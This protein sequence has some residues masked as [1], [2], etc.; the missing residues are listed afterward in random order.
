MVP[1]IPESSESPSRG[2]VLRSRAPLPH[3]CARTA[4]L[5]AQRSTRLNPRLQAFGRAAH[6]PA[7]RAGAR[8]PLRSAAP[9]L[10]PNGPVC[11]VQGARCEVRGSRCEVRGARCERCEVREVRN[12][13]EFDPPASESARPTLEFGSQSARPT[14]EFGSD[15]ARPTLEFGSESAL[16]LEALRVGQYSARPSWLNRESLAL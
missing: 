5:G 4:S 8:D 15:P 6:C 2:A 13:P 1:V 12:M 11:E 16:G 7:S 14:L 3:L 9:P 10:R